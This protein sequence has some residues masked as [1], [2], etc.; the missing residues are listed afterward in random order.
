M[1]HTVLSIFGSDLCQSLST[2]LVILNLVVKFF[3][4]SERFGWPS[5]A[6]WKMF[7]KHSNT[8]QKF[9]NLKILGFGTF[10][11]NETTQGTWSEI[12]CG[13]VLA[14]VSGYTTDHS[15]EMK[16]QSSL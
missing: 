11:L 2:F 15:C 4:L 9:S 8:S 1:S 6:F 13:S 14:R 12:S 3:A 5:Q 7:M 16:N 10:D